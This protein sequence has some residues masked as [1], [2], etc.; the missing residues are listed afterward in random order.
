LLT[1]GNIASL[2]N[3]YYPIVSMLTCVNGSF[4]GIGVRCMAEAFLESR[5]GAAACI[6][7]SGLS[8]L[9][10]SQKLIHGFYGALLTERRKRI[11]DAMLPAYSA[12]YTGSG[13]TRELLFFELF[14]DPAMIVNP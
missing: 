3:A 7:A 5:H 4:H 6:A 9:F 14:G 10:G 8:T 13:N 1:A 12:L 11:G 2:N